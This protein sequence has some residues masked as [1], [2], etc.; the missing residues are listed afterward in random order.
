METN[1]GQALVMILHVSQKPGNVV[2]K[3]TVGLSSTAL[4]RADN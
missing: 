4:L 3:L 1:G 2:E